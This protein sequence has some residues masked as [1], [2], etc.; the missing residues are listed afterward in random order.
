MILYA[1]TIFISAF[2]L[3]QVQPMIAKMI[4]PWF[5][6]ISAVWNTCMLFFQ[7]ILLL[8]YLYA[9]WVHAQPARRQAVIHSTLLAVSLISL[10]VRPGPQWK[11]QD[12]ADPTLLIL[13]LLSVTIGLP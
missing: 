4:L 9:H 5:G 8:G 13:G 7:M 2:L 6:G 3:F 10:P 11:P 1:V 12:A